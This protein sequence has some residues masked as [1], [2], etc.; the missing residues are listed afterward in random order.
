MTSERQ[1]VFSWLD[2]NRRW[3]EAHEIKRQ[4]KLPTYLLKTKSF[5]Q[6][7]AYNGD[8]D[9][10]KGLLSQGED[11]NAISVLPTDK[12]Y[13]RY[14]CTA[15]TAA[16]E[17]NHMSLVEYLLAAGSDPNVMIE[18]GDTPLVLAVQ[19][20]SQKIADILLRNSANVNQMSPYQTTDALQRACYDGNLFI[21][22]LLLLYGA[23]VN[24]PT[25]NFGFG[26]A[27][28]AAA[29][30]D[31]VKI[32]QRLLA[33][34]ADVNG[35]QYYTDPSHPRRQ[36]ALVR[37]I[38]N[39]FIPTVRTLLHAGSDIYMECECGD[40][41][42]NAAYF[43]REEIFDELVVRGADPN[44][45]TETFANAL[46]AATFGGQGRMFRKLIALGMD[47]NVKSAKYAT[48]LQVASRSGENSIVEYLLDQ[49]MDVNLQGGFYWTA[50]IAAVCHGNESTCRI[51][52][53]RG[54]NI[55]IQN[56]DHDHRCA[57]HYAVEWSLPDVVWLLLDAGTPINTISGEHG[58]VLQL[59]AQNTSEDVVHLLLNCGADI[60]IQAGYFGNALQA[61]SYVGNKEITE[62][63][64]NKG[65]RP[66]SRGGFYET[67][68]IA[69]IHGGHE[70]VVDLLIR[71]GADVEM[72]SPSFGSALN[73]AT[74]LMTQSSKREEGEVYGRIVQFLQNWGPHE[75]ILTEHIED[76]SLPNS[77]LEAVIDPSPAP[78]DCH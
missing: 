29:A 28:V 36:N 5:L 65:A 34:G 50:L 17:R 77:R 60:N 12:Q 62:L 38:S 6:L 37:A 52:I 15:L 35:F 40:A 7:A 72:V 39:N 26:P 57:L 49:G 19:N 66:N 58:T 25:G 33:C 43:G 46:E 9:A 74:L 51:L 13:R 70:D 30:S 8:M 71:F 20:H 10:V 2:D 21:V 73:C 4:K 67:A 16:V 63:L 24:G 3:E 56:P 64:L 11:V 31:N 54:A 69:A 53:A 22:N 48:L 14:R 44:R 61:W 55:S 68:L 47:I 42:Q 41:L 59:A 76:S 27:L 75:T 45:E 23:D 78:L 18:H 1:R 32:I